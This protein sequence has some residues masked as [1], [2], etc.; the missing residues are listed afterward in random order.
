[1]PGRYA[2]AQQDA[3]ATRGSRIAKEGNSLMY[4]NYGQALNVLFP[5]TNQDKRIARAFGVTP[6]F[7]KYLRAG[8]HWTLRRVMQAAEMFGDAWDA[9]LSKPDSESNSML[10]IQRLERR[11]AKVESYLAQMDRLDNA[12]MAS[13]ASD[14]RDL[15]SGRP[16][17]NRPAEPGPGAARCN[18]GARR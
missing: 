18:K 5:G 2:L 1:M 11:M 12:P 7:A 3:T 6:R 16:T 13:T 8:N 9:A 10:E 17:N 4:A 14:S 15:E